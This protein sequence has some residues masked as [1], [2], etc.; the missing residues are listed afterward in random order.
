M[1][2]S[3]PEKSVEVD[4]GV[5]EDEGVDELFEQPIRTDADT[6]TTS[7]SKITAEIFLDIYFFLS[8]LNILIRP[9]FSHQIFFPFIKNRQFSD[10]RTSPGRRNSAR[11][12]RTPV[13]V[14]PFTE[15]KISNCRLLDGE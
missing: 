2:R 15:N 12:K 13:G 11:N 1:S 4:V 6:N 7:A 10:V 14:L 9:L 8:E 5:G 3:V